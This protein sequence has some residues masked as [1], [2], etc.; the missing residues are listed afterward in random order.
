MQASVRNLLVSPRSGA[1]PSTVQET[2]RSWPWAS[3]RRVHLQVPGMLVIHGGNAM[4]NQEHIPRDALENGNNSPTLGPTAAPAYSGMDFTKL[5]HDARTALHQVIG[6][7]EILIEDAELGNHVQTL[8]ALR[9][10][11]ADATSILAVMNTFLSLP[12]EMQEARFQGLLYRIQEDGLKLV[13]QARHL[14][15]LV[16]LEQAEALRSDLQ[17]FESA[18]RILVGLSDLRH[19]PTTQ[20][21]A[22][23]QPS[24]VVTGSAPA[25]VLSLM[26][27][28]LSSLSP[29]TSARVKH[30]LLVV[31]DSEANRDLLSRWLKRE[32]YSVLLA[33]NGLEA[34]E[35]VREHAVDLILLDVMMPELDGIAVLQALKADVRLRHLPVIMI[36]ADNDIQDVVRCIEMGAEDYLAKPFN[37]ILL[38]ARVGALLERRRL[39]DEEQRKSAEL[40]NAFVEIK[41][42]KQVAEEL[43]LNILPEK[44]ADE[45]RVKGF[46]EPMYFEDVTIVFAD[47]AGFTLS[48][49][50]LPAVTLVHVLHKYF[51]AFDRI[52]ASYELEKLK[53]IGDCYMFA[54]GMPLRSSSHPVESVLAALEMVQVVQEMAS[55][56]GPVDWQLRVGV[57]TGPVIAGVVGIRKFAFDIW[58]DSVNLS[59]RMESSGAPNRVNL[60]AATQARVKDFFSCQHRGKIKT[61]DGHKL[62]MYFVGGI[63][64]SLRGNGTQT[65]SVAFGS[66]YRTYFQKELRSFPDSWMKQMEVGPSRTSALRRSAP[67][68]T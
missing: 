68:S 9:D 67:R 22:A 66:R 56:Q 55:P 16:K 18:A 29:S 59:A 40:E 30:T 14:E 35:K 21:T 23:G 25:D 36:S 61:K 39:R 43:L 26:P 4:G 13:T 32:G 50:Q 48:T 38:R 24:L 42:Q 8:G 58:G 63:A 15:M 60:S 7:G 64:P 54:G 27:A 46:V 28:E 1:F 53:T 47:F 49:E 10:A 5:R 2:T 51:T 19:A 20:G 65:A 6:Y 52:M 33:A 37:P 3:H 45:L 12:E 41:R 57:H 34:L 31:D 62:D 44:V 11:L 17:K